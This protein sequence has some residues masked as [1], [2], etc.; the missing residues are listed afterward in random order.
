MLLLRCQVRRAVSYSSLLVVVASDMA[1]ASSEYALVYFNFK[2]H[3]CHC[4]YY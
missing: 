3:C 4:C 1:A 2:Q